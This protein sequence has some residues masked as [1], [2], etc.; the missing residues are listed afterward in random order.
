[1]LDD[2]SLASIALLTAWFDVI[3][4]AQVG[5]L[6]SGNCFCQAGCIT[7]RCSCRKRLRTC[8]F[9]CD[10]DVECQNL[11]TEESNDDVHSTIHVS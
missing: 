8:S 2:P 3:T 1:M 6:F 4:T 10:P 5:E 7:H 11:A 9:S